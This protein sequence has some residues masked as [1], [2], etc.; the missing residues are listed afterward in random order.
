MET[1][2]PA[3]TAVG[4]PGAYVG[5]RVRRKEDQRL[6]TGT[7]RYMGDVDLPRAL[8]VAFVRSPHAHARVDSINL[9]AALGAPGVAAAYTGPRI[10]AAVKPIRTPFGAPSA[11]SRFIE[12]MR[13]CA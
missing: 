4:A 1:T 11:A 9:D 7:A 8:H 6:V 5:R 13:A 12:S 10:H 2:K 3:S